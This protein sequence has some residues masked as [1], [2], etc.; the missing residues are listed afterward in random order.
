V[1]VSEEDLGLARFK[2]KTEITLQQYEELAHKVDW[3]KQSVYEG[4]RKCTCRGGTEP[5]TA[6][7]KSEGEPKPW[8]H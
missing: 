5:S 7:A 1:L 6:L 2:R 3:Q 4:S 8:T